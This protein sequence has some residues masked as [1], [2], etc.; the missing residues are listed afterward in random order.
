MESEQEKLHK[1]DKK[2]ILDRFWIS[3][4]ELLYML[5]LKWKIK[6][7]N[8]I[9]DFMKWYIDK[10]WWEIE[11]KIHGINDQYSEK[12]KWTLQNKWMVEEWKSRMILTARWNETIDKIEILINWKWYNKIELYLKDYIWWITLTTLIVAVC[13]LILGICSWNK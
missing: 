12:V 6:L 5:W 2:E 11:T 10:Y 3:F 13:T 4:E 8:W 9:Y 1:Y 7:K